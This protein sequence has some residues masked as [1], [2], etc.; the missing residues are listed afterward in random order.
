[1][2]YQLMAGTLAAYFKALEAS[3]RRWLD[4]QR[5]VYQSWSAVLK[6]AYP[7]AENEIQRRLDSALL[8]GVSLSQ[9]PFDSQHRLMQVT[10]KWVAALNRSVLDKLEHDSL[11]PSMAVVRQALQ[12]GDVS[13][14]ALSKASRQVGHFA[15]T[16][17]SSATVKAAHDMRHAWKLR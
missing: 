12:L 6:P 13:Y 3:Q 15:S 9:V 1:M 7:L 5:D 8:A 14:G 10:E 17:F 11:H 16:S 4:A 2:T